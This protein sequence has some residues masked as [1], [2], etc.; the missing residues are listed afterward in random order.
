MGDRPAPAEGEVH[1]HAPGRHRD[2]RPAPED[3]RLE[4]RGLRNLRGWLWDRP[5]RGPQGPL[6][7]ERRRLPAGKRVL[8]DFWEG[9]WEDA[10]DPLPGFDAG[11]RRAFLLARIRGGE[12]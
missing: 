5:E 11:R 1:E 3:Q 6:R 10:P 4:R 8:T 2:P 9:L 7:S 12:R